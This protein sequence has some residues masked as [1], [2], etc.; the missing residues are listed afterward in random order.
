MLEDPLKP[1]AVTDKVQD[2]TNN[3][4]NDGP[5]LRDKIFLTMEYPDYS[6]AA[7]VSNYFQSFKAKS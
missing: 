7:F 1:K 4:S 5:S 6:K 2:V 3:S